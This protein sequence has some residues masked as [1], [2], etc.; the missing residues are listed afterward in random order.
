MSQQVVRG[1]GPDPPVLGHHLV[2]VNGDLGHH[3]V[4]VDTLFLVHGH[5]V[6]SEPP[7]IDLGTASRP[8][9]GKEGRPSKPT[10]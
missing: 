6:L 5:Q 10:T 4:A 8:P 9:L 2:G 7:A 1:L 3:V